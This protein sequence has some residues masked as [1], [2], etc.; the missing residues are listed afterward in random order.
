[1]NLLTNITRL[2]AVLASMAMT[3]VMIGMQLGIAEHYTA[4]ASAV[5]AARDSAPVAQNGSGA[6][7]RPQ[8]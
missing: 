4:Q 5:M 3:A 6:T 1:V 8:I 7:Q 2:R